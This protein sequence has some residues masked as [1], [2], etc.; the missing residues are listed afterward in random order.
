MGAR[1]FELELAVDEAA[2]L[3]N[4]MVSVDSEDFPLARRIPY[5]QLRRPIVPPQL[6]KA[7]PYTL[8][9]SDNGATISVTSATTITVPIAAALGTGFACTVYADGVA[10][11]LARS[12]GGTLALVAGDVATVRA[13][14]NKVLAT[15]A[16]S[17]LL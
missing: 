14:N 17:T 2:L 7:G 11:T 8:Q 12:G 13:A 10:V 9:A 3:D 6:T 5:S 1:A 15:K 4:G 16:A